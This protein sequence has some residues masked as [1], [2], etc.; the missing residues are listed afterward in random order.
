MIKSNLTYEMSF[1]IDGMKY[2]VLAVQGIHFNNFVKSSLLFS[3]I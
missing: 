2:D 1:R 3:E